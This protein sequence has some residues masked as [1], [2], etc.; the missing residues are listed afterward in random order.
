ML[1]LVRFSWRCGEA[2]VAA[3]LNTEDFAAGF[4]RLRRVADQQL[5][6]WRTTLAEYEA[7]DERPELAVG[8]PCLFCL[9]T[10]GKTPWREV[11]ASPLHRRALPV[12]KSVPA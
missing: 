1:Q 2:D 3:D 6:N 10:L 7:R 5:E 9:Q 4:A 11:E 8:S 12:V